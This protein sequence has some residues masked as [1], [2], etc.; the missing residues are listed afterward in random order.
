MISDEPNQFEA[1]ILYFSTDEICDEG[2]IVE[3]KTI[4]G[5]PNEKD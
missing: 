4:V 3:L 5:E 1:V 2:I